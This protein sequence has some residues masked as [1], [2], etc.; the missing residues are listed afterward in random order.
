MPV[1][2]CSCPQLASFHCVVADLF[3]SQERLAALTP[4]HR[5][6]LQTDSDAAEA[7][8]NNAQLFVSKLGRGDAE[9]AK[10]AAFVDLNADEKLLKP[11]N[12]SQRAQP[13]LGYAVSTGSRLVGVRSGRTH[14]VIVAH[15][16]LFGFKCALTERGCKLRTCARLT[17]TPVPDLPS[18]VWHRCAVQ[19]NVLYCTGIFRKGICYF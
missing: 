9:A 8:R 16:T 17:C 5:R 2:C 19:S 7:R 13:S 14:V 18:M 12:K 11:S 15:T 1:A 10:N 6:A 3:L 4:V